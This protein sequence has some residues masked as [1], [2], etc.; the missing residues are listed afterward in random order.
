[1]APDTMPAARL[2]CAAS[3]CFVTGLRPVMSMSLG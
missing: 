1:V 2:S 3:A